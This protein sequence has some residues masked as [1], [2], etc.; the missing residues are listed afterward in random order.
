MRLG[1]K[2]WPISWRIASGLVLAQTIL[3]GGL[4]IA[5]Q[6]LFDASL[7]ELQANRTEELSALLNDTLAPLLAS[8]DYAALNE[9]IGRLGATHGIADIL[10]IDAGNARI[11]ARSGAMVQ[12]WPEPP[13]TAGP[14]DQHVPV[15]VPVTL[16]EQTYGTLYLWFSTHEWMHLRERLLRHGLVQGAVGLG[17]LLAFTVPIVFLTR[18]RLD[19][20]NRAA[21]AIAAGDVQQRIAIESHDEVGRLAAAF[22]RM[23]DALHAR[24]VSLI[25]SELKLRALFELAP[26][27]IAL[28]R[29]E[30]GEFI[31]VNEAF[32]LPT[33]YSRDELL[34]LSYFDLTPREY[35]AAEAEQLQQLETTGRYGPYH[36]EYIRKTGE[37]FPVR[38]NGLRLLDAS[39]QR[40]IWS[41]AEDLTEQ[42]M[43]EA[44][45]R[46]LSESKYRQLFEA[47]TDAVVL[48]QEQAGCI[49]CNRAAVELFGAGDA[50]RLL[51][52]HPPDV[53]APVQPDGSE[54]RVLAPRYQERALRTGQP[55]EWRFKRFD[56]GVPFTGEVALTWVRF[57]GAD[58]IQAVIRDISERKAAEAEIRELAFY[59]P[60]TR[61]PNRRLLLERIRHAV[62]ASLRTQHGGALLF[63]DLDDFKLLNDSLGHDQGD[64]FL[65]EVAARLTQAIRRSDTLSRLGGDE[66][67]VMLEHL[68][69]DLA[70]ATRQVQRLGHKLLAAVER[71]YRCGTLEHRCSASIGV[72]FFGDRDE[73]AEELMKQADLAMYRAKAAG[74][75]HLCFYAP[76]MQ[77][78]V[79]ARV[80]L[81]T[82]LRDALAA[83]QFHLAYQ[84]CVDRHGRMIGAEALLRWHPPDAE[85]VP[86]SLFIPIAERTGLILPLGHW[87]LQTACAQLAVWSRDPARAHWR[88][89][90]NLSPRQ[91]RQSDLVASILEILD[92]HRVPP[93]RLRVEI[94]ESLLLDDLDDAIGK[95]G[96]LR[97]RG[98]GISLDDFGTGYSSLAYLKRLPLDQLK[99]DGSFI[100]QLLDDPR[101]A[102]IVRTI[103]A[104][105]RSLELEVLAEGVETRAQHTWLAAAGCDAYQGYLFGPPG[106]EQELP[107]G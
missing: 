56:T 12:H 59:D 35:A 52:T 80:L 16:L 69:P 63:I 102:A 33:G 9:R 97:E 17:L 53:S 96:Q 91:F 4:F 34:D 100:R 103:I 94:T 82:R 51:G 14:P 77:E 83:R 101:D 75:N 89:S 107:P 49:D 1:W 67:V 90:V 7:R 36:K 21:E 78:E 54:S 11:I 44:E 13:W 22:N 30:T 65:T 95:M 41:I 106:P 86:P 98:I 47:T 62:Q 37:R 71:P 105:A 32:L 99:I 68:G 31:E 10:L 24:E 58:A 87:V 42:Q 8:R 39:G 23:S 92:A 46:R 88:M 2:H 60:L 45:L 27:G 28:N 20:L 84:P 76:S 19:Q 93:Q 81:E 61:L 29:M 26:V 18:R 104:L 38:L 3:I 55:F 50:V 79:S 66:F 43:A 85:P 73:T 40:V 74:R 25:E 64:R 72:T 70:E 48:Y 15:V 5:H 57:D 6:R